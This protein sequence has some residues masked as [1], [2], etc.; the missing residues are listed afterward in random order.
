[1][2]QLVITAVGPDRP[3]LVEELSGF[4]T[5]LGANIADA[6]MVN[7]RGRFAVILSAEA[8]DAAA[9]SIREGAAG[10]GQRTGLEVSVIA[11]GAASKALV[12]VPFRLK[13]Y[14]MDQPGIV[15]R[16]T[17]I[18]HRHGVNIEELQ[19]RLEAGAHTGTPLFTMDLRM[20]VPRGVSVKA[21]RGELEALCDSLNCDVDLEPA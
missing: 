8:P 7:L 19:T 6:R 17:H 3:G 2:P 1:M 21:L 4:L 16:I 11:E 5:N 20:T 12:G 15:H 13:T 14:S 10:V 18:L 9:R